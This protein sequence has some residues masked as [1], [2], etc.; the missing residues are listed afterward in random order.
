MIVA[1][2]NYRLGALGFMVLDRVPVRV[3]VRA[4]GISAGRA[5]LRL[6]PDRPVCCDRP[7]ALTS[8]RARAT[9]E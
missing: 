5:L 1:S 8:T 2:F 9:A 4:R 6:V 3:L 7:R